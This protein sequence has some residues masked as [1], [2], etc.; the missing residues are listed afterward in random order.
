MTEQ[1]KFKSRPP[2]G[3]GRHRY[4]GAKTV[5][6]NK[7]HHKEEQKEDSNRLSKPVLT[8]ATPKGTLRVIPIGGLEEIGRNCTVF[9][10]GDDIIVVDMGI[11]FPEEDMPGIDFIIPNLS[12]LKGKE[13]RIRGV[14]IT[15]GHMDHLG[16]IPY[17]FQQIGNPPVYSAPLTLGIIQR[18]QEEFPRAPKLHLIK[19]D[20]TKRVPI[21]KHF[22]IEPFHVNHNITDSFGLLIH[23]PVGT[24]AHTG[25]FKFDYTPVDEKPAEI[26]RLA[27]IGNKG[28]L[29][30]MA[31]ST[32]A[33][34]PGYQISEK[35]VGE[36]LEQLI[37]KAD[38]RII[39]GAFA[40][41]LTRHQ[42]IIDIAEKVGRKVL[43][44]GR[45]IHNYVEIAQR[46]KYFKVPK[47]ILIEDA[48]FNKLPDNKVL[49]IC[50]G[51][52]GQKNSAL[53]RIA[54]NEHRLITL[55]KGDTILFSSS[56]IP[57][58]ERTVERLQDSLVRKGAN[59]Y[60]NAMMDIHSGGHAKQEDLKLLQRLIRPKYFIPIHGNHFR[61]KIHGE[62]A[63]ETGVEQKNVF[64]ADNGQVIEFTKAGGQLTKKHVPADHVFVDGLGVGDVSNVVLRERQAMAEEGMFVIIT[65]I[66]NKT[67]KLVG[68]PDII[69]RG[70]IYM[71]ENPRL[72]EKV[73]DKVKK[74][75]EDSKTD[76]PAF[77]AYIK[78][79]IRNEVGQ[80]LYAHT[81]RRP[82][83]LPV[84]NE[85]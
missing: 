50:T 44:L 55:K 29:A 23:T 32:N 43:L 60:N 68:E 25:D 84:V 41:L 22:V 27:E 8:S 59:V 12:Y 38:G 10:Y 47:G 51:A 78:E 1:H 35:D 37:R 40:S 81:R 7:E 3:Q 76:T 71:K 70:F 69:S 20:S 80:L 15:H 57:G 67:G 18:R 48:D 30:L 6:G 64:I 34:S 66:D 17:L 49:V 9:E 62:L 77:D 33:T 54:S 13:K 53:M 75:L 31:D 85:V 61:L 82:M 19:I 21:G 72:I 65:T 73:R 52:M 14:F 2:R 24:I 46:L 83:V 39:I 74:I 4:H 16:A 58:N 79:K 42:Q 26:A 11:Q 5:S 28:V 36:N 56:V 45:S 63:T